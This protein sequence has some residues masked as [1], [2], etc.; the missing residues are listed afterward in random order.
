[1]K[2]EDTPEYKDVRIAALL[3]ENKKL[4]KTLKDINYVMKKYPLTEINWDYHIFDP[5]QEALNGSHVPRNKEIDEE[6][7]I[8]LDKL[9]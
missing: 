1:M 9:K 6:L 3:K 2:F 4:I 7:Q 5:I 8:I